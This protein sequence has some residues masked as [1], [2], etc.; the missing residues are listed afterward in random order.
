MKNSS[1]I[2]TFLSEV[3]RGHRLSGSVIPVC[4]TAP[5]PGHAHT[6]YTEI[7]ALLHTQQRR[8]CS[9]NKLG[10]RNHDSSLSY[11]PV[12]LFAVFIPFGWSFATGLVSCQD[13][14]VQVLFVTLPAGS[15]PMLR[16]QNEGCV[17]LRRLCRQCIE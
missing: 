17:V 13:L 8:D 2:I 9:L 11:L 1:R 10:H 16:F 5:T 6:K 7:N 3:L 15:F 14:S 4:C 12:C